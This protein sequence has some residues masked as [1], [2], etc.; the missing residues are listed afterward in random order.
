MARPSTWSAEIQQFLRLL[1]ATYVLRVEMGRQFGFEVHRSRPSFRQFQAINHL[2]LFDNALRKYDSGQVAAGFQRA[3]LVA[4]PETADTRPDLRKL[5]EWVFGGR[6]AGGRQLADELKIVSALR[7]TY[8]GHLVLQPTETLDTWKV[9]SRDTRTAHSLEHGFIHAAGTIQ[10]N[11]PQLFMRRQHP[12]LFPFVNAIASSLGWYYQT[13]TGPGADARAAARRQQAFQTRAAAECH[14]KSGVPVVAGFYRTIN[15]TLKGG[16]G[17]Q[18]TMFNGE[19]GAIKHQ[20]L[21]T[22]RYDYGHY[23]IMLGPFQPWSGLTAPPC[24]YAESSW[25]QAAVQTAL[26]LFSALYPAPCISGYAR[27]PGPSAVIEHLGSLVPKGGL[28]LFLSHLPDD[29]KDGLGE[30]GPARALDTWKV[31]SRDTRTAHSL[32]HGFIHAAGTIQANCPQLFMRRQHPGLFPFVNAIASSLGWYYQTATG[33]GADARAAARR[34]QAFQTRAAAECHAKS[35]VPVVAGFYR[36]INATL[37]GGEGLQPTMFNGELGAIKHQALDT[38]RY[39]YGHYLRLGRP[40][41]RGHVAKELLKQRPSLDLAIPATHRN[42]ETARLLKHWRDQRTREFPWG[43][44]RGH[45][46]HEAGGGRA[47]LGA[48][49]RAKGQLHAQATRVVTRRRHSLHHGRVVCPARIQ[50]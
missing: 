16:E 29:V 34:Q 31:L 50:V 38:V 20:A 14:A 45:H 23:L 8:S 13:A 49:G 26:E 41:G 6:A 21:D 7:D 24:P 12:G 35:G 9:L 32:E 3:L 18:P 1:G 47:G 10:A 48:G 28:L 46:G 17:L 43:G 15:A 33:P 30:M 39:D 40:W 2:V 19:L 36:T 42:Q 37:K 27:P 11:C 4:G 22:V 25:A 5:N 44:D